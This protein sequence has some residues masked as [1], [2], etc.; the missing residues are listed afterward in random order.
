M[1]NRYISLNN[2]SYLQKEFSEVLGIIESESVESKTTTAIEAMTP[3]QYLEQN[4]A[5]LLI[6]GLKSL[7]RDRPPNAAEY[8]AAYLLANSP[9]Q[10]K[11]Q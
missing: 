3:R 2:Q 8:L 5:P 11:A 4:I 9:Q 1:A 7:N 10:R 6:D